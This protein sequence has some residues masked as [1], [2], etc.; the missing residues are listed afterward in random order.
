M[1]LPERECWEDVTSERYTQEPYVFCYFLGSDAEVRNIAKE[2]AKSRSLKLINIKHAAGNYHAS[3]INYGDISPDAPSPNEFLS[4]IK[5]ADTV[6]TDSFHA[7]VFSFI[8]K[9]QFFVFERTG[10]KSMSTRITSLMSLLETENRFCDI[11]ERKTFAYIS[12]QK[13]IDYDK[14]FNGFEMMRENS[15]NFLKNNLNEA[16]KKVKQK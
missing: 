2:Y 7:S 16:E 8:F 13:P 10:H 14:N 15:L 9:R 12:A 5:Y 6:F 1:L 4:L 11:A 3:D